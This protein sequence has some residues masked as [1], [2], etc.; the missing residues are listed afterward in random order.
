MNRAPSTSGLRAAGE[1][2][3]K[4]TVFLVALAGAVALWACS[5]SEQAEAEHE[6]ETADTTA[7]ASMAADTSDAGTMESM[8]PDTSIVYTCTMHPE[9]AQ[10]KPGTCPECNM[11]L[12][13]KDAP[14][15]TKYTCP[16]HEQVVQDGPG[17][18]PECNKFLVA[19]V[20]AEHGETM[21]GEEVMEGG[22]TIEGGSGM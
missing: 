3:M 14:E 21:Q 22:S 5:T 13:M 9:V 18:C 12:V 11:L 2:P 4:A 10:D 8:A 1:I 6:H 16:M 17:R 7:V 15:G 19:R 20:P